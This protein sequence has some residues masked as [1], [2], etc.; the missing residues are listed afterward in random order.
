MDIDN[1]FYLFKVTV[2]SL[3]SFS[4]NANRLF[5]LVV[6]GSRHVAGQLMSTAF[7]EIC[8]RTGE[9]VSFTDYIK[10]ISIRFWMTI[11]EFHFILIVLN[12]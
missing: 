1:K 11:L 8:G 10:A 7:N 4:K 5:V 3:F 9:H 2:I 12:L 6:I